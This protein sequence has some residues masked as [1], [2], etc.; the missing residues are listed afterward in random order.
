V[1]KAPSTQVGGGNGLVERRYPRVT[2]Q[3]P[4][5]GFRGGKRVVRNGERKRWAMD[6]VK[7]RKDRAKT[8][9]VV[10][11][12]QEFRLHAPRPFQSKT[13]G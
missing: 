1:P 10:G 3:Q 8:P 4:P 6:P 2:P 13:F 5:A 7:L 12:N 9:L 11:G